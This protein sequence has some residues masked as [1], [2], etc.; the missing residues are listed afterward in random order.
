M[1]CGHMCDCV[2]HRSRR[3]NIPCVR[4]DCKKCHVCQSYVVKKILGDHVNRCHHTAFMFMP[5][6]KSPLECRVAA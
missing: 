3:S 1:K 4:C 5:T 6:E 2:C